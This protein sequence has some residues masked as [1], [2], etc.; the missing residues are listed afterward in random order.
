MHLYGATE[1]WRFRRYRSSN[2]ILG[3]RASEHLKRTLVKD[4]QLLEGTQAA[5]LAQ[6]A[7]PYSVYATLLI[8]PP[9]SLS[10][11]HATTRLFETGRDRASRES[12]RRQTKAPPMLWSWSEVYRHGR[13]VGVVRAAA[14]ETDALRGWIEEL[15]LE[16]GIKEVLG[17]DLFRNAFRS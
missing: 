4:V 9:C 7:L 11:A 12:Q 13:R 2:S 10:A 14:Q 5:S 8:C 16:A 15:M 17:A 3:S 6:H 1:S